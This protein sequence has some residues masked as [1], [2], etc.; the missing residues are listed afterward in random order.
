MSASPSCCATSPTHVHFEEEGHYD[1]FYLRSDFSNNLNVGYAFVNF[2]RLEFIPNFV[3]RRVGKQWDMYGSMKKCEV[4]YA[5]IQGIDCLLAKFR[6]SVVMEENP[7]YRPKL[8]YNVDSTD[9]PTIAGV[10]NRQAIGTEAA[11]HCVFDTMFLAGNID[12]I[13]PMFITKLV[14]RRVGKE[15]NT[16]G[17]M[18]KCEVFYATIQGVD[19]LP[20]K[21][22]NSVVTEEIVHYRPKLWYNI[23][24]TDLLTI[25][26]ILDIAI[27]ST[28]SSRS[29]SRCR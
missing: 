13:R 19:C 9:L 16:Y 24:L 15:W 1:S 27:V 5:T 7:R 29:T 23:D 17:S 2:V 28:D 21:F 10:P 12:S 6:N 11:L 8:W 20:A 3:Q 4:S 26:D 14:Q 18:E 22:R 25:A